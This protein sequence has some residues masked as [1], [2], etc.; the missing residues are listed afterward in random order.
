[1]RRG[2]TRKACPRPA[3]ERRGSVVLSVFQAGQDVTVGLRRLRG[4]QEP[5]RRGGRPGPRIVVVGRLLASEPPVAGA[6]IGVNLDGLLRGVRL[7][8]AWVRNDQT[9]RNGPRWHGTCGFAP[10]ER[11]FRVRFFRWR[12]ILVTILTRLVA[13]CIHSRPQFARTFPADAVVRRYLR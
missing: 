12:R 6:T 7:R 2:H 1:M 3:A 4:A 11:A 10:A 9:R 13:L 5:A 8:R